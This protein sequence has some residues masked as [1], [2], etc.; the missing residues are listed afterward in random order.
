[1]LQYVTGTISVSYEEITLNNHTINILS[2]KTIKILW[3]SG[4]CNFLINSILV[5]YSRIRPIEICE[6]PL[7]ILKFS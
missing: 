1:M 7:T 6:F 2:K 3:M 5:Y 4:V